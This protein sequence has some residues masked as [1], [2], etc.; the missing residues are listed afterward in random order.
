MTQLNSGDGPSTRMHP[1]ALAMQPAIDTSFG[2]HTDIDGNDEEH[3]P[4][5]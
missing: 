5:Y 3:E 2:G 1:H 4:G